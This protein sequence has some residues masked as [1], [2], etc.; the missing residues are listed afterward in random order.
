MKINNTKSLLSY[1]WAHFRRGYGMGTSFLLGIFNALNIVI[2]GLKVFIP[3]F[4]FSTLLLIYVV[5]FIAIILISIGFDFLLLYLDFTQKEYLIGTRD[6]PAVSIPIGSKEIL[7]YQSTIAAL[8]R[9]IQNYE[10]QKSICNALNLNN[11]LPILEQN[12]KSA[13][14]YKTKLED[15]LNKAVK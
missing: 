9:E 7:N 8:N 1:A 13:Q 3:T 2:I 4:S 14:E 5:G 12:I 11:K 6:N 10:V 15:M